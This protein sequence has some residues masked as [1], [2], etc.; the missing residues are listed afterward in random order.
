MVSVEQLKQWWMGVMFLPASPAP[1]CLFRIAFGILAVASCLLWIPDLYTWFGPD[2]LLAPDVRMNAEIQG[3][4]LLSILP[5]TNQVTVSLFAIMLV[6]SIFVMLGFQSR[7]S[8]LVLF[9]LMVS[10]H[11]RSPIILN[12]GDTLM[13]LFA[14]ILIFSQCGRMFSL[15]A[16]LA[17]KSYDEQWLIRCSPWAQRLL[18]WQVAAAYCQT[19]FA[20]IQGQT[21]LSGTA[22]YYATR[23]ESFQ[24]FPVPFLFDNIW[25]IKLLTWGTLAIEFSLW[26]LIWIKEIRYWILFAGVIFHLGIDWTMNIP[27]FEYLMIAAYIN[28]VDPADIKAV[29]DSGRSAMA[30]RRGQ[31]NPSVA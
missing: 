7:L 3:F 30:R 29:M 23:L 21:W 22:I 13:R 10:F 11:H 6:S 28:F 31:K 26:T 25:C 2:G 4:S 1:I 20:K 24:R 12:S 17:G 19:F 15:D 9:I 5:E 8:C 18:Q 14:F 16:W 27:V